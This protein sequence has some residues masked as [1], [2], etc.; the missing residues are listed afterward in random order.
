MAEVQELH[1]LEVFDP[2]VPKS[3]K[4]AEAPGHGVSVLEHAPRSRPAEAYRDLAATLFPVSRRPH[5]KGR[6]VVT[7]RRPPS[8][9]A[10][11]R[12]LDPQGRRALFEMPVEAA[13]DTIR[14]GEAK[15][16]K[17]A[18][19]LH[20]PAAGRLGGGRVQRLLGPHPHLPDRPGDAPRRGVGVVP[21]PPPQPLDALPGLRPAPLVRRR[22]ERLTTPAPSWRA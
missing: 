22:V 5:G 19:L 13:R 7:G 8:P 12:R 21:G 6:A 1:D 20:G 3:V 16:G 4:A 18:P 9:A 11:A 17:E 2:P 10:G 14:S 15:E